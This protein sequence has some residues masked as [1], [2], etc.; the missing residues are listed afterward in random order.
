MIN[1]S[2]GDGAST[3]DDPDRQEPDYEMTI[4]IECP[5]GE[6]PAAIY[7][8]NLNSPHSLRNLGRYLNQVAAFLSN[9]YCDAMH[10]D[11]PR[12]RAH[13]VMSVVALFSEE[14]AA[15]TINGML[16]AVRGV[17][18]E[19]LNLGQIPAAAYEQI[20]S[21][22]NIK[23]RRKP[24]GRE[25]GMDQIHALLTAC[26]ADRTESD[27][28]G[29]R[30]AAVIG[31][32]YATGMKRSELA[33]LQFDDY[34]PT[35]GRLHVQ[36]GHESQERAV[37]LKAHPKALLDKWL[38]MRDPQQPGALLNPVNKGGRVLHGQGLSTQ[39]VYNILK[40]RAEEADIEPISPHDLRRTFVSLAL[41]AGV[42]TAIVA[43][44]AGH[45]SPDTTRR[46]RPCK[47]KKG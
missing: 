44:I 47:P 42:K 38:N 30:D 29:R 45:N 10:L 22:P 28:K 14:Y 2:V 5:P 31:L 9:G 6:N 25:L 11:W 43:E 20:A 39:A 32:L 15:S 16:S 46:Y 19:V 7:L 1:T 8:G 35:T 4:P 34:D 21:I 37:I 24:G 17:M 27:A 36:A 41:K 13:H 33:A 18:R 23:A 3:V 26:G 40:E 12:V